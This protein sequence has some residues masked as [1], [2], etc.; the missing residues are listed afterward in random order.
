MEVISFKRLHPNAKLPTKGSEDAAGLDLY[1]IEQ[2]SLAPGAR[3][4]IGTGV[5][6]EIPRGF[7]GRIAPRSGL[8]INDGIDVLG[9]V[10]DKDYRGEIRCILINLGENTKIFNAGDRIAQL[11]L[12]SHVSPRPEWSDEL[13]RTSRNDSGFGSSGK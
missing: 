3:K 12:E 1:S 13:S 6:V 9:G 2:V 5:S 4:A 10:I 8:A 11:I 7:Y